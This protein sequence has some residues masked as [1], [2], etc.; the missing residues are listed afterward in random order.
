MR[1]LPGNDQHLGARPSQQD[2]FGFSDPDNAALMAHGGL[3]AVVADGM[4]GMAHGSEASQAATRAF[5]AAYEAKPATESIPQALRRSLHVANGAVLDLASRA[6]AVG[7][8]GTT[9]TAVALCGDGYHL[10]S[11]GDSGVYLLRGGRLYPQTRAHTHGDDLDRDVALRN[12]SE[13]EAASDPERHALTSFLGIERLVDVYACEEP[14]PL[15]PGDRILMCSDGLSKVLGEYQIVRGLAGDPQQ[16]AERLVEMALEQQR[17][18]QDN[19]TVL[20]IACEDE[21][22][23]RAVPLAETALRGTP[24]PPKRT[25]PVDLR[26]LLPGVALLLLVT[27]M[28]VQ[29]ACPGRPPADAPP[30]S[31]TVQDPGAGGSGAGEG[32]ETA[33]PAGAEK[34]KPDAGAEENGKQTYEQGETK[35]D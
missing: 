13:T 10:I 16:A 2:A 1:F 29:L 33:K 6:G 28:L 32:S 22:E 15:R 34:A 11:A 5:L 12:I 27:W 17:P 3:V 19:V 21:H 31:G 18:D 25:S 9:L 23:A 20:V 7:E 24:G 8:M 14:Q 26:I 30:P 35:N 4:G